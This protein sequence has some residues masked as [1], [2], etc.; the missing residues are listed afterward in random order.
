MGCLGGIRFHCNIC[1]DALN[2][3]S[4]IMNK[5]ATQVY[6]ALSF[7]LSKRDSFKKKSYFFSCKDCNGFINPNHIS[8]FTRQDETEKRTKRQTNGKAR[9]Y[10]TLKQVPRDP[11]WR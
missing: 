8:F 10:N 6:W 3:E 2:Y 4:T 5:N 7:F 11:R 1:N 9:K